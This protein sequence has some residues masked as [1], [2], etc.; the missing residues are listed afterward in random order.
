MKVVGIDLAGN[1]KN[2]TGFC[3]LE[4][5]ENSKHIKTKILHSDDE[6]IKSIEETKPDLIAI[7]A[8]LT[9]SNENRKCDEILRE[10]GALPVTLRGMEVLAIRGS[11][12]AKK[13]RSKGF[14]DIIEIFSTASAKIL[15]LWDKTEKGMQKNLLN[16]NI[17]GD[18]EKKLL[19][20]D[21]LDAVFA[22][23]T[24]YLYLKNSTKSVGDEKG[25]I[26]IPKV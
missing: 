16:A 10:Y 8:P 21:E 19:S 22:A 7:D 17:R 26:I 6:I 25:K 14:R 2:D 11:E 15:G 4:D 24:G 1:P 18:I 23:I 12:L 5:I 3:I 20:K 9:Y 13:L